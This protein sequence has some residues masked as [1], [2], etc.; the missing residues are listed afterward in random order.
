MARNELEATEEAFRAAQARLGII[1]AYLAL[2]EFTGSVGV[3]NPVATGAAWTAYAV[4]IVAGMR[5]RSRRL[6][7][8]YYQLARAIDAGSTLGSP[9][10]DL[11]STQVQLS[12]LRQRFLDELLEVNS[13]GRELS[14]DD[15]EFAQF[16]SGE[17]VGL[18][19]DGER[20]SKRGLPLSK[21]ELD[22]YIQ[23]FL[24]HEGADGTIPVEPFEWPEDTESD[25]LSQVLGR[26]FES[27]LRE[28]EASVKDSLKTIEEMPEDKR[29]S[30]LSDKHESLG[31]NLVSEVHKQGID[32]G[33]ETIRRVSDVDN[34]VQVWARQTGPRPCAF[35][36]MLASR[37]FAYKT[38]QSASKSYK[39]F[40]K[41]N[42]YLG[43]TVESYHPN[44]ACTAIPRWES[45]GD[46][47]LPELNAFLEKKWPEVT[48]GF[49]G[50]DA[51][52]AWRR[53]L[54][55][56]YKSAGDTQAF[57]KS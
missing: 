45:A 49:S 22:G 50:V 28:L 51:L 42:G 10:G 56:E 8:A 48:K 35:C 33:N 12:R 26:H 14:D 21:V 3:A 20:K 13:L 31:N 6:S 39:T 54:N 4:Q 46:A 47:D 34:R 7:Q 40:A 18:Q 24:D 32:A 1:G 41:N 23:N 2:A 27:K 29:E 52:N 55:A 16:L 9:E 44:C 36:A 11:S 43:F 19:P 15:D 30:A 37:G 53:W 17:S 25:R 38:K 5:R 57:I